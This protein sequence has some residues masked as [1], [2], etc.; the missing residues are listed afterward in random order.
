[1]IPAPFE[2]KRADSVDEAIQAL[3]S[4]HTLEVT[5]LQNYGNRSF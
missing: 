5:P 2:Y 1:M 4:G 3:A